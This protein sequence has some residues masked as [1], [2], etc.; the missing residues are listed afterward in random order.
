MWVAKKSVE[1]S[2]VQA[3]HSSLSSLTCMRGPGSF[4]TGN[5]QF[6]FSS[7]PGPDLSVLELKVQFFG[8]ILTNCARS[9]LKK[10]SKTRSTCDGHGPQDMLEQS[11]PRKWATVFPFHPLCCLFMLM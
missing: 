4:S 9:R 1:Q 6:R 11:S 2:E 7:S 3:G 8:F 5:W 10:W